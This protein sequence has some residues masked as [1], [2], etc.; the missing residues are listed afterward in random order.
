MSVDYPLRLLDTQNIPYNKALERMVHR[1]ENLAQH[2]SGTDGGKRR[3]FTPELGG[4]PPGGA[5]DD[6]KHPP[7]VSLPLC[8]FHRAGKIH[9][10]RHAAGSAGSGTAANRQTSRR[11]EKPLQ[12]RWA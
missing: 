11:I 3:I 1:S 6:R 10:C 5:G 12:A 8:G 2:P 9:H 7:P 4:D